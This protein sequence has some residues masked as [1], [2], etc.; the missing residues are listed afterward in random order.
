MISEGSDENGRLMSDADRLGACRQLL[1][2]VRLPTIVPLLK[3]ILNLQGKPYDL[4]DFFPVEPIFQTRLARETMIKSGRQ[5]SKSVVIAARN[6]TLTASI[7]YFS[8]LFVSPLFE[9]IRRFSTQYVRPFIE[10]SPI[11][12]LLMGTNT[13]NSVLQRSFKNYSK[14]YFSFAYL[15]AERVRGISLNP[16]T[17]VIDEVQDIDSSLIPVIHECLSADRNW[18]L[19]MYTGTPKSLDNTIEGFWQRS[20]QAEWHIPC[21]GCKYINVPSLQ[22]DLDKMIGPWR[23]TISRESPG[24]V[25]AK[26]RRPISSR[27]GRWVH[28][29]KEKRW[30]FTGYHIPQIIMPMHCEDEE[31]WSELLAKRDGVGNVTP[32]KFYNEVLGESYDVGAKLISQ[33]ELQEAC[34]LPWENNPM[35]PAEPLKRLNEYRIRVLAVDWGGGGEDEVSFTKLAVLG[36]TGDGK[37]D[38]I[39]GRKLN[40]PHDHIQEAV[41]ILDIYK[42]FRCM[43]LAHD[44]TG[45]GSLRET[46]IMQAGVPLD[47]IFPVAYTRTAKKQLIYHKPPSDINPRGY[48]LLDKA[49]SL[50]YTCGAI[51]TKR[52]RFFKWD[53]IDLHD[54]PGLIGDF[55]ALVE[56]KME[57]KIAGE[58]Y[59]VGRNP[60]FADDFAQAVNIGVNVIWN[61]TGTTPDLGEF[62]RML[63]SQKQIDEIGP[64]NATA[65]DWEKED[66]A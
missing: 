2:K 23:K 16:G 45:A 28:G 31:K 20:S 15:D 22:R 24:T 7:P 47:Q 38:V 12:S 62:A 25:C 42:K 59:G 4:S 39:Y 19:K 57:S 48:W 55:L 65:K 1:D 9:Q 50:L 40:T 63:L 64:E 60:M 26:C 14:M 37:V 33:T 21:K 66:P 30:K 41:Q 34:T 52:V 17:V 43:R 5:I 32:A 13:E 8:V 6:I 51:R 49:R 35:N 36:F 3:G 46:F 56:H 53:R 61:M 29:D 18:R 10:T 27:D 11:K 44:Y 58:V 54:R